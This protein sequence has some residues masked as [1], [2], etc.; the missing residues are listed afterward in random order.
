LFADDVKVYVEIANA[1][2]RC[3]LRQSTTARLYC[4][5]YIYWAETHAL[6]ISVTKCLTLH[7]GIDSVVG[8]TALGEDVHAV[9]T[10]R[11]RK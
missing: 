5:D 6:P 7:I 9:I 4:L 8:N 11:M 1:R 2:D 10:H 3:S